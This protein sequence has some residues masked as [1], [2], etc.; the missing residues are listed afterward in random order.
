MPRNYRT[1]P[2]IAP[3]I[4]QENCLQISVTRLLVSDPIDQRWIPSL[5]SSSVTT[6]TTV[7]RIRRVV[8]LKTV[9]T[10]LIYH[11]Y[12]TSPLLPYSPTVPRILRVGWQIAHWPSWVPCTSPR[13]TADRA[14]SRRARRFPEKGKITQSISFPRIILKNTSST[15]LCP[16]SKRK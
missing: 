16:K 8:V 5:S 2:P 11:T 10:H 4:R 13:A 15:T 12:S 14:G 9:C 6:V 1:S 3:C 7:P